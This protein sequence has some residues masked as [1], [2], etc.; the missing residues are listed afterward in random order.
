[1]AEGQNNVTKLSSGQQGG[2]ISSLSNITDETSL[3]DIAKGYTD[4][5][6]QFNEITSKSFEDVGSRQKSLIGNDFGSSPY[7]YDTYY[8]SA[9]T[10]FQSAMRYA[11]TQ[12]AF[13]KGVERSEAAAQD[14]LNAAKQAYSDSVT[15]YN[16]A[17]TNY[18]NYVKA[19]QNATAVYAGEIGG[20]TSA[21]ELANYY[22]LGQYGSA[23]EAY[24]K[25]APGLASNSLVAGNWDNSSLRSGADQAAFQVAKNK[26]LVSQDA[27]LE[28]NWGASWWQDGDVSNAWTNNYTY[29]Y[30][31]QVYGEQVAKQ[32]QAVYDTNY[33]TIKNY[34]D[35]FTGAVDNLAEIFPLQTL[36]V[37]TNDNFSINNSLPEAKLVGRLFYY[38]DNAATMVDSEEVMSKLDE[39]GKQKVRDYLDEKYME[40]HNEDERV[41]LNKA[42][43]QEVLN[44]LNAAYQNDLGAMKKASDSF[45]VEQGTYDNMSKAVESAFG[46]DLES[47]W[48]LCDMKKNNEKTYNRLIH[49]YAMVQTYGEMFE[50]ADGETTYHTADGDKVL[51][52]GTYVY[53][54]LPGMENDPDLQNLMSLRKKA[55]SAETAAEQDSYNEAIAEAQEKYQ[56]TVSAALW[57]ANICDCDVTKEIV[58][59]VIYSKNPSYDSSKDLTVYGDKTAKEVLEQFNNLAKS[60]SGKAYKVLAKIINKT[61]SN[62]GSY[63]ASV[64]G[65][66]V[67]QDSKDAVGRDMIGSKDSGNEGL[68]EDGDIDNITVEQA[69]ALYNVIGTSIDQYNKGI[70]DG[71]ISPDFMTDDGS[72]WIQR[73]GSEAVRGAVTIVDL[74]G[75][76]LWTGFTAAATGVYNAV[77]GEEWDQTDTDVV[78]KSRRWDFNGD[79]GAGG[80][81]GNWTGATSLYEQF[82]GDYKEGTLGYDI[83]NQDR[84][85]E[86][87]LQA[88]TP[89]ARNLWFEEDTEVKAMGE[90][91]QGINT[92]GTVAADMTGLVG[93]IILTAGAGKLVGA[94]IE[95][96]AKLATKAAVGI[97][98]KFFQA[99]LKSANSLADDILAGAFKASSENIVDDVTAM[100]TKNAGEAVANSMDDVAAVMSDSAKEAAQKAAA[101]KVAAETGNNLKN[102]VKAAT[103]GFNQ[104]SKAEETFASTFDDTVRALGSAANSVDDIASSISDDVI[105]YSKSALKNIYSGLDDAQTAAFKEALSTM[106]KSITSRAFKQAYLSAYTGVSE[107]ALSSMSDDALRILSNIAGV[108]TGSYT[109]LSAQA[110][111]FIKSQGSSG[112]SDLAKQIAETAARKAKLGKAYTTDDIVR[113]LAGQGWDSKATQLVMKDTLKDHAIDYAMDILQ[114]YTMPYVTNEGTER[115]DFK[116]YISNP[117]N[118][119]MNEGIAGLQFIGKRVWNRV[120]STVYNNALDRARASLNAVRDTGNAREIAIKSKR[121]LKLIDK[122]SDY[123]D[124]CLEKGVSTAKITELTGRVDSYAD[125]A[126]DAI[127]ESKFIKV[128]TKIAGKD[129]TPNELSRILNDNLGFLDSIIHGYN[130]GYVRANADYFQNRNYLGG[131]RNGLASVVDSKTNLNITKTMIEARKNILKKMNISRGDVTFKEQEKIYKAMVD[132]ACEQYGKE[133]PGL[134]NQ[135]KYFTDSLMSDAKVNNLSSMRA[136]YLPIESYLN[137]SDTTH[138]GTR[139]FSN[140]SNILDAASANPELERSISLRDEDIVDALLDGKK[141]LVFKD[142]K[143]NV[144]I[145]PDTGEAKTRALNADGANFLDQLTNAH[146]ATLYN[147][148]I[149][150]ETGRSPSEIAVAGMKNGYIIFRA[151]GGQEL[152]I[153]NDLDRL[154]QQRAKIYDRLNKQ[155][156]Q[157]KTEAKKADLSGSEKVAKANPEVA[158]DVTNGIVSNEKTLQDLKNLKAK[159]EGITKNQS[160]MLSTMMG[161]VGENGIIDSGAGKQ[162]FDHYKKIVIDDIK[163]LQNGDFGDSAAGHEVFNQYHD[164]SKFAW[165]YKTSKYSKFGKPVNDVVQ[166]CLIDDKYAEMLAMAA[167]N[168]GTVDADMVMYRFF[169]SN[170]N[171]PM[172]TKNGDGYSAGDAYFTVGKKEVTDKFGNKTIKETKYQWWSPIDE[173]VPFKGASD[174][175]NLKVRDIYRNTEGVLK[176]YTDSNGKKW[177]PKDFASF[178]ITDTSSMNTA[179]DIFIK[180]MKEEDSAVLFTKSGEPKKSVKN[181]I[182]VMSNQVRVHA[183]AAGYGEYGF[184]LSFYLDKMN[185]LFSD[186]EILKGAFQDDSGYNDIFEKVNRLQGIGYDSVTIYDKIAE[187]LKKKKFDN[188]DYTDELKAL[189]VAHDVVEH[190]TRASGLGGFDIHKSIGDIAADETSDFMSNDSAKI[191][192]SMAESNP[193][194]DIVEDAIKKGIGDKTSSE[195]L[196]SEASV[197]PK[198]QREVLDLYRNSITSHDTFKDNLTSYA[199]IIDEIIDDSKDVFEERKKLIKRANKMQEYVNGKIEEASLY[200]EEVRKKINYEKNKIANRS[201]SEGIHAENAAIMAYGANTENTIY[202]VVKTPSQ[203]NSAKTSRSIYRMAK[204]ELDRMNSEI[205]A[206]YKEIKRVESVLEKNG[207]DKDLEEILSRLNADAHELNSERK[208]FLIDAGFDFEADYDFALTNSRLEASTLEGRMLQYKNALDNLVTDLSQS[209]KDKNASE[210]DIAAMQKLCDECTARSRQIE[211]AINSSDFLPHD[212]LS[213][214]DKYTMEDSTELSLGFLM[215]DVDFN[216]IDQNKSI[217]INKKTGKAEIIDSSRAGLAMPL[218]FGEDFYTVN[219]AKLD[220]SFTFGEGMPIREITANLEFGS[221]SLTSDNSVGIIPDNQGID[222]NKLFSPEGMTEYVTEEIFDLTDIVEKATGGDVDIKEIKKFNSLRSAPENSLSEEEKSILKNLKEKYSKV[223]TE[224]INLYELTTNFDAD[225]YVK[226]IINSVNNLPDDFTLVHKSEAGNL[227]GSGWNVAGNIGDAVLFSKEGIESGEMV[228]PQYDNNPELRTAERRARNAQMGYLEWL[229][230]TSDKENLDKKISRIEAELKDKNKADTKKAKAAENKKVIIDGEETTYKKESTK[231]TKKVMEDNFT[232]EERKTLADIEAKIEY[233]NRFKN[234]DEG[235]IYISSDGYAVLSNKAPNLQNYVPLQTKFDQFGVLPKGEKAPEVDAKLDKKAKKKMKKDLKKI[236]NSKRYQELNLPETMDSASRKQT[237]A[238]FAALHKQLQKA[239]GDK[240][241]VAGDFLINTDYA[242]LMTRLGDETF[243]TGKIERGISALSGFSQAI[244]NIQLA[245]GAGPLNALTFA[246]MRGAIMQDPRK[247]MD[248]VK[249]AGSMRNSKAV[250]T[251]AQNNIEKL[252]HIAINMNAVDF[253]DEFSAA[254]ATRPGV[255]DGGVIQN[256]VNNTINFKKDFIDAKVDADGSIPKA[257][258]NILKKDIQETIFEDAT[259]KNAMPVLKAKMLIVNYDE[260]VD[261]LTKKF[262][263]KMSADEID[264]AASAMSY[265]KTLAYFSP[266]DVIGRDMDSIL[267]K[268]DNRNARDFVAKVINAKEQ[269]TV[270]DTLTGFFFALRYKMMLSG[271]VYDAA[272]SAPVSLKNAIKGVSFK[273]PTEEALNAIGTSFIHSGSMAGIGSIA[274]LAAAAY[275][276]STALGIPTAWDDIDFVGEDGE[277]EIPNIL[278][279]FQTIGQIWVPNAYSPENGFYVDK[280]KTIYGFDS[281]SSIFTLQNSLFRTIDKTFNPNV[282]YQAP[283]RGIGL[284]SQELG[285]DTNNPVNE[286]LNWSPLRA[287]GDELIGSN[288]LSPYKA[289]YEV[290]MDTTYYGNNIWEKKKLPDGSDNPNYDP[291][292]NMAASVMHILGLDQVLDGGKGY[293]DWVKGKVDSDGNVLATYVEQDQV[294]TVSGSGILQHEYI[295]MAKSIMEGK[296]LEGITDGME[297]PIKNKNLTSQARTEFNNT[298]KNTMASYYDDYK[299]TVESSANND[300]KDEAYKTLVTKCANVVANWSKKWESVLGE[301]QELV[302]S[303]TR[304]MMAICSGEYDDN[305]YYVQDAFWKASK[306]AQIEGVSRSDWWLDDEDLEEWIASGKTAEE[307]AEE[308]NKRTNAYNNALDAEYEARQA[309]KAAGIGLPD[310]ERAALEKAGILEGFSTGYKSADYKAKMNSINKKLFTQIKGTLDSKVGEFNNFKEMKSYYESLIDGATTTK[311]KAS[312][313]EKYNAYV[314]DVLAPYVEQYGAGI[315]NDAYYNNTGLANYLADYII[316][317]ANQYYSGKSPRAN[318]IKDYFGVGYR[319]GK[320]LPTDAEIYEKFVTAQNL[321]AKGAVSSSIAVLD[322]IIK[323]IKSGDLYSSDYDYS[324]IVNMRAILS[325]RSK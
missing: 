199:K 72:P 309:L 33:N 27:K 273:E 208:K 59:S 188:Q 29:N 267:A 38:G 107:S 313:A 271:R 21:E 141:E 144:I 139:G 252:S 306:D 84:M 323:L 151:K 193:H 253:L 48:Y 197:L 15:N 101:E 285:V 125:D 294:G 18:D 129:L 191:V 312:I 43:K 82:V 23:S 44:V 159:R 46:F 17:K 70:T 88:V 196:F 34:F 115:T 229:N 280:S 35:Y 242:D 19:Q 1:M 119:V 219:P 180:L 213:Y 170:Q 148:Y 14:A 49:D 287:F 237:A 76:I 3:E 225:E 209:G 164:F 68:F 277:F 217:K 311:K 122:A 162:V 322:N 238:N 185:E 173:S 215:G 243:T 324:K 79:G 81:T 85:T 53:Y 314:F 24:S 288:L 233:I 158:K 167:K 202:D 163:A 95:G 310:E 110:V 69:L 207:P 232:P 55:A 135:L 155:A 116:E 247:I 10:G 9:Q 22:N 60:D 204:D 254:I 39:E 142:S 211:E 140:G 89:I 132:A 138:P 62:S 64:A 227:E 281:L 182:D 91:K 106:S 152:M 303:V 176:N 282:M 74:I 104:I 220:G 308:K 5:G 75:N 210:G 103:R 111:E 83:Q 41:E 239:V 291:G 166:G 71:N 212:K 200:S 145:D 284:I 222:I 157:A 165:N 292:R 286:A 86:N 26:G 133:I 218:A 249:V 299:A 315:I 268:V 93:S 318:Y 187:K 262:G 265:G 295:S 7:N 117:L 130:T 99:A 171:T 274:G 123:A 296:F 278:Q 234:G 279:K 192:A 28:D 149:A 30:A 266:Y 231:N 51:E 179:K 36:S 206:Q 236:T 184:D 13:E 230:Y 54:T 172:F 47:A 100:Y 301:N 63:I 190:K 198:E 98:S 289:V 42:A 114:G 78:F 263:G 183:E 146:N 126:I 58:Q 108:E 94:V 290:I 297:L 136:G 66:L 203:Y 228:K 257:F 56:K 246:Q 6:K 80:I 112:A 189:I 258:K 241:A 161:Y 121:V 181:F 195:S 87:L 77:N 16:N 264:K 244:Q 52:A 272:G 168:N 205:S 73:A 321:A 153:K 96:G 2:D 128:A 57:C 32:Y 248:Y 251:F 65:N 137:V 316:L 37:N 255:S 178:K 150:V 105:T 134:R 302:P 90:S 240:N 293:N 177:K 283:Q 113:F 194:G 61:T 305:M 175:F 131:E 259:F 320:N 298:I 226:N 201:V 250:N 12:Y 120:G 31:N 97:K 214:L 124:R 317:P 40:G 67:I 319:N 325:A 118:F 186:S 109:K 300:Q 127:R 143:G 102:T 156:K 269:T 169:L 223:E 20:S 261:K 25:I 50:V 11:G 174:E 45:T 8:E 221:G 260:A 275:V 235:E 304:T 154:Y 224:A 160:Q 92:A 270:L 276:T 307:F 216:S 147:K 256:M 4:L 245:G